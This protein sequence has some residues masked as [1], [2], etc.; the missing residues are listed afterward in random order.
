MF[1]KR[2]FWQIGLAV[3]LLVTTG[4]Q[5]V[6]A[7]IFTSQ[8]TEPNAAVSGFPGPYGDV[9]VVLASP[10]TAIVEFVSLAVGG[11]IYLFGG[12]H[13]VDVQ[14]NAATWTATGISG[15]NAGVGFTPGPLTDGG[16]NNVDGFGVFNE[17]IDSSDGFTHSSDVVSFTLT[18]TSGT[19][20]SAASVLAKNADGFDAAAHIFVTS[21]PANAANGATATGFVGEGRGVVAVPE[22][23]S[24]VLMVLGFVGCLGYGAFVSWRRR[25]QPVMA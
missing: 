22:P 25:R 6:R 24:A 2:I 3:G 20:A 15:T 19:W 12:A 16:S 5:S 1:P 10:T 21:F 18:N 4:I 9:V 23:G 17:T 14:V 7:D 11:N 8:L 13:A